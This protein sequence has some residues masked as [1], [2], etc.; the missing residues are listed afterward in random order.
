MSRPESNWKLRT[1]NDFPGPWLSSKLMESHAIPMV[2]LI[3]GFPESNGTH[4]FQRFFW[5]MDHPESNRK[6]LNFNLFSGPWTLPK[7]MG[8]IETQW[9]SWS[10]DHP[11]SNETLF[12]FHCFSGPWTP[13]KVME[14]HGSSVS[15]LVHGL[16][17]KWRQTIGVPMNFP[18]HTEVP[19]L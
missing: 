14:N 10:M 13:P 17:R 6:P 4:E 16:P 15:F 9:F 1:F 18:P 3:H 7:V 8:T 11:G 2:F 12:N 19:K 5:S